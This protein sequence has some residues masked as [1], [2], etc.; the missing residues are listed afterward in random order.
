MV[1]IG[2]QSAIWNIIRQNLSESEIF[3]QTA[4][5]TSAD[6][7]TCEHNNGWMRTVRAECWA[8]FVGGHLR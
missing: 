5:V 4:D 1:H 7:E 8:T 6:D 2:D 3:Q